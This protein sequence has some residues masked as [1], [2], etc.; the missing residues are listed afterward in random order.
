VRLVRALE[1][2]SALGAVPKV[3][4]K[5]TNNFIY[6]GLRPDDLEVRILKRL[7]IR[8]KPMICEGRRLHKQ[9]LSYKRMHELGLEYRYI[10]LYLQNKLTKVEMVEELYKEIK[11]YYKRQMTWFKRNKKIK[12]FKPDEFKKIAEYARMQLLGD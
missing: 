10:A 12:W 4:S 8:L 5:P 7:L 9:G 11:R 1:I 2:V 6:L 3:K